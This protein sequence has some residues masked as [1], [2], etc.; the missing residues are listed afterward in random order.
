[1]KRRRKYIEVNRR[2]LIL[3]LNYIRECYKWKDAESVLRAA[4]LAEMWLCSV[5]RDAAFR[6]DKR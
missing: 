2:D 6:E 1:M 5:I 4:G 3:A